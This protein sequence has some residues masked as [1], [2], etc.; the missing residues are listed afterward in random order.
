MIEYILFYSS[1]AYAAVYDHLKRRLSFLALAGMISAVV[2]KAL[3]I[4]T[5]IMIFY[6]VPIAIAIS[7]S[8]I[9]IYFATHKIHI[10]VVDTLVVALT[11]I[12]NSDR[13]VVFIYY[14]IAL[15]L[16]LVLYSYIVYMPVSA[17]KER[18]AAQ[19]HGLPFLT[20]WTMAIFLTELFLYIGGRLYDQ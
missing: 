4:H 14:L 18:I 2:L 6:I 13:L 5:E 1:L 12:F 17:V 9:L 11:L 15:P 8:P 19:Y 3:T 7:L 16:A 20:L 10:H